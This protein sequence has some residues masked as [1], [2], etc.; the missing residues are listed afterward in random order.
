MTDRE[1]IPLL[2]RSLPEETNVQQDTSASGYN[3]RMLNTNENPITMLRLLIAG[4]VFGVLAICYIGYTRIENI[5]AS[6]ILSRSSPRPILGH[7][8]KC[9]GKNFKKETLKLLYEQTFGNLFGTHRLDKYEAS[10]ITGY[11]GGD[12][13]YVVFDNSFTIGRVGSSIGNYS[14]KALQSNIHDSLLSWPREAE[15]EDSQFEYIAYNKTS[16]RYLVGQEAIVMNDGSI[17][18]RVFEV[19]FKKEKVVVWESCDCDFEFTYINKGFEGGV[20]VDGKSDRSFLIALCEGNYCRGKKEGKI[21]H[22]GRLVVMERVYKGNE[23]M[24]ET[25]RM[26]EFDV[27]FQD[28]SAIAITQDKKIGIISQENS[29][30]FVAN[31]D[32]GEEVNG[33]TDG[34]IYDFPRNDECEII[35]CNLEG[36]YFIDEK[37]IVVVSDSMKGN[38]RQHFRCRM[39]DESLHVFSLP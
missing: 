19:S 14:T 20:I 6:D 9:T 23:C 13:L 4:V 36:L 8:T 32:V 34:V 3:R 11:P 1:N 25:K 10:D 15:D 21:P 17:R 28:Y 29:A 38:G 2:R 26:I 37:Q 22:G 33:I 35:Y 31:L 7:T 27:G 5:G 39:K 18:S 30:M 12:G 24:F 16:G